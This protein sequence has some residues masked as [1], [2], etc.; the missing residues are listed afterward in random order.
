M[1]KLKKRQMAVINEI[2]EGN[3]DEQGILEKYKVSRAIF[4]KWQSDPVFIEELERRIQLAYRRS[5]ALIS[6]YAALAAVKLIELTNSEN[7]ETARKACVDIVS[8]PAKEKGQ[9]NAK[10]EKDTAN[11]AVKKVDSAMASKLL[12]A[13]ASEKSEKKK[14]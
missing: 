11:R 3:L 12:A 8:I 6:K 10:E 13:L 2:F 4:N 5:M 1:R 9:S 7:Q 14:N